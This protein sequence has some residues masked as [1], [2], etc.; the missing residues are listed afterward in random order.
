MFVGASIVSHGRT[1]YRRR[2]GF[3]DPEIRAR[4]QLQILQAPPVALGRVGQVGHVFDR[5]HLADLAGDR[6]TGVGMDLEFLCLGRSHR[7]GSASGPEQDV[8]ESKLF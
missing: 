3:V 6:Q 4:G 2:Y 8:Q 1:A 7:E 5:V